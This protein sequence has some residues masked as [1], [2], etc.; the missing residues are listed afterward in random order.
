MTQSAEQRRAGQRASETR[1]RRR[2]RV[3]RGQAG[4]LN[5]HRT[6]FAELERLRRDNA[7]NY[8]DIERPQTR[9]ECAQGPRPCPWVSCRFSLYL[10]STPSGNFKL[11]FPDLEPWELKPSCALDV[12]DAGGVTLEAVAAAL[13]VTREMVRQIE[14][15]ALRKFARRARLAGI[16]LDESGGAA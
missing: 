9:G 4:G 8:P 11:N 2:L 5:P 14:V 10:D 16:V 13:N 1:L 7:A 3:V 6:P 15:S 12:A